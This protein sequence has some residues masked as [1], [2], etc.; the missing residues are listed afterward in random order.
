MSKE[1]KVDEVL[2]HSYSRKEA[3]EDGFLVDVSDMGREAGFRYPVALTR[4]VWEQ[5]VVVPDGVEC[6]DE[7]GRLWDILWMLKVAIASGA[8]D[9][10]DLLKFKLNVRN[11]NE[12][13]ELVTLKSVCGPGDDG[14]P[15]I[16]VMLSSED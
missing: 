1:V 7:D 2:I 16:T 8:K 9:R 3:I 12:R 10:E 5:Y 6:Q 4:T 15:V 13:T 11:A 14:E